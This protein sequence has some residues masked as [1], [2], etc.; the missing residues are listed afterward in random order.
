MQLYIHTPTNTFPLSADDIRARETDTLFPKYMQP[1][2]IVSH[3][4]YPVTD[5]YPEYDSATQKVTDN[6]AVEVDGVWKRDYQVIALTQEELDARAQ[7]E[8]SMAEARVTYLAGE[9]R[10]TRD[11]LLIASDWTQVADAPVDKAV[12]ATYRQ[13]L[14][15]VPEQTGFPETIDWPTKP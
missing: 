10:K 12:W 9:A 8:A 15:D 3:G 14:R 7:M 5:E 2:D 11:E 13:A 1:E 6:G 4:Y